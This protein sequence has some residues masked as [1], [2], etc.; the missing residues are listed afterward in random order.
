MQHI[1]KDMTYCQKYS[2]RQLFW[3]TPLICRHIS[4][5]NWVSIT[6]MRS[7]FHFQRK[8]TRLTNHSKKLKSMIIWTSM[9]NNRWIIKIVWLSWKGPNT[10]CI[11]TC[12]L[13]MIASRMMISDLLQACL[14]NTWIWTSKSWRNSKIWY[15]IA[16]RAKQRNEGNRNSE[17]RKN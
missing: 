10:F 12:F 3:T 8:M 7:Q 1:S 6:K 13:Q 4:S 17:S 2:I 11:I 9:S 14:K 5:A 15:R 16:K